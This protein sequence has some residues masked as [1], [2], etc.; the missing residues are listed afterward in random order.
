VGVIVKLGEN[1]VRYRKLNKMTQEELASKLDVSRQTVYKW[2][3]S[4]SR[5]TLDKLEL[6]CEILNITY[7]QLLE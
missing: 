1:I 3:A 2:E 7:Q 4:L 6:I 5:P